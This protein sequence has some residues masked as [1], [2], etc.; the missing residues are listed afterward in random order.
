MFLPIY[1]EGEELTWIKSWLQGFNSDR[2][3]RRKGKKEAGREEG[4]DLEKGKK[5]AGS[6]REEGSWEGRQHA[7][8]HDNNNKI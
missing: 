7:H 3:A 2:F 6:L 1:R 8:T 4:R 5:K